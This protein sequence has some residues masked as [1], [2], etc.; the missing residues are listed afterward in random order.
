MSETFIELISIAIDLKKFF[1]IYRF[2][3]IYDENGSYVDLSIARVVDLPRVDSLV[4]GLT[5]TLFPE[6]D[7]I[8]VRVYER[9][10]K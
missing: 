10:Y 6:G 9:G 2:E 5:L 4:K 8:I 1:Q 3:V 7:R